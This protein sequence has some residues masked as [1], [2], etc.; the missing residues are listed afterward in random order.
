[1]NC[2]R[3]QKEIAD[4]SNFCYFCGERQAAPA[5]SIPAAQPAP[6]PGPS[7][8]YAEPRRLVRSVTDRKLGGVCAGLAHYL[9]ADV[10]LIRGLAICS[11]LVYGLGLLAYLIA[12][13]VIPEGDTGPVQSV[14]GCHRL[15]RSLTNKK[16]GGVCGGV[17]EYLDA[18]PTIIRLIWAISFFVFG[19]GGIFYL[20]LWFI[21]PVDRPAPAG[22]QTA[23]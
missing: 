3:C 13:M 9:D 4:G 20:V 14:P 16:I 5:Q 19:V 18:D 22:M 6:A 12:W 15:H 8:T 2:P 17:A 10:T 7:A 21:L 11:I 23:G 1:M